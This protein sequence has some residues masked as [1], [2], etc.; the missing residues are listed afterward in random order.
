LVL[1]IKVVMFISGSQY[2]VTPPQK[3]GSE[4]KKFVDWFNKQE[5]KMHPVEFAALAHKKFVFIHP[6]IDGNGMLAR[7]LMNLVLLL[8][9][10]SIV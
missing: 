9:E 2:P 3:V 8:N 4:M 7:L 6:F 5:T 1:E 10:Y